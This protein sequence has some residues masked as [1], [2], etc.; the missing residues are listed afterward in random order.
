[1]SSEWDMSTTAPRVPTSYVDV[2]LSIVIEKDAVTKYCDLIWSDSA[3][4]SATL[5]CFTDDTVTSFNT[6]ANNAILNTISKNFKLKHVML[7]KQTW[8]S[9]T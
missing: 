1:M 8:R 6:P 3:C 2:F 4:G 5:S 9:L 7:G